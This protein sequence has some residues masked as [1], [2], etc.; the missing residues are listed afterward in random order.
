M[1]SHYIRPSFA[2][3]YAGAAPVYEMEYA[4][5]KYTLTLTDANG[6]LSKYYVS[7]SSG[8]SVSVSGNTLTLTSSKPINDAVTIKRNRPN[9][10]AGAHRCYGNL[11]VQLD[12]HGVVDWFA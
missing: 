9:Q 6:I 4:N 2:V 7:Q 12:G 11:A 10:K 1:A 3:N 8:V 5:G